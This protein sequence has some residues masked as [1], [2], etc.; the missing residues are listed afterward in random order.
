MA[1]AGELTTVLPLTMSALE[2]GSISWQHARVMVDE[3]SGLGP[4]GAQALEAHFL[5]PDAPN[6]ARGGPAGEL[7]PGRFR[8]KARTWRE[9][10]PT[11][12]AP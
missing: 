1:E 6:P 10:A 5:D 9:R 8:A 3:T 11:S 7:V 4:E 2:A 12:P